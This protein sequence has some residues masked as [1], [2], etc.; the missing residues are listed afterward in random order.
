[1]DRMDTDWIAKRAYAIW[2]EEGRPEGR[3]ESHWK[4]AIHD[5][6]SMQETV[7]A[8]AG[9]PEEPVVPV[10]KKPIVKISKPKEKKITA[11]PEGIAAIV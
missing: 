6:E 7:G 8:L 11:K 3:H 10:A 1:M 9:L 5:F 2:E 4:L